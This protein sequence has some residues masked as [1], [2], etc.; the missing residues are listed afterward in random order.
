MILMTES[1]SPF[2]INSSMHFSPSILLCKWV[3]IRSSKLCFI[4]FTCS[5]Y[6]SL[7]TTSK[8]ALMFPER[9]SFCFSSATK[10]LMPALMA[11]DLPENPIDFWRLSIS[12]RISSVSEIET[13]GMSRLLLRN[14]KIL[15]K[16]Y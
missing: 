4:P 12:L 1:A 8:I 9:F 10:L 7:C 6:S 15:T 3:V 11:S 13:I 5:S 16:C 2:S 14:I